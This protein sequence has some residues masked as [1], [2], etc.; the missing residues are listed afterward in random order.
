MFLLVDGDDLPMRAH[1]LG[2]LAVSALDPKTLQPVIDAL[3]RIL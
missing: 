3:A 2:A 1:H